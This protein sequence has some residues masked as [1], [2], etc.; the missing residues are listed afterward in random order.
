MDFNGQKQTAMAS[1]NSKKALC[2]G[3]ALG[4]IT[5]SIDVLLGKTMLTLEQHVSRG[6]HDGAGHAHALWYKGRLGWHADG[7]WPLQ[8]P[9]CAA[10]GTSVIGYRSSIEFANSHPWTLPLVIPDTHIQTMVI[11]MYYSSSINKVGRW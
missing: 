1:L 2:V 5:W 8:L 3:L 10:R 6:I 4:P 11:I 7:T 9:R